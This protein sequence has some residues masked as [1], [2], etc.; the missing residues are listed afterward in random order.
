MSVGDIFVV[1]YSIT[2]RTSFFEALWIAEYVKN[3]KKLDSTNLVIAGTKRDLEHFRQVQDTEGSKLTHELN[4]GFYEI[5]I[6]EGFCDTLDMFHDILR[7]YLESRKA[8]ND[9]LI[10]LPP[11]SPPSPTSPTNPHKEI[12]SP[13]SWS[14]VKGL[15]TIPFRR[16]SVQTAAS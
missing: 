1:L 13:S 16:K 5:S 14:K 3:R 9:S 2:D 15:R 10:P 6:S 12:K 8:M 4:C 7:Q 11:L